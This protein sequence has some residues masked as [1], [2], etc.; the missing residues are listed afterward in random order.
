MGHSDFNGRDFNRQATVAKRFELSGIG[1]HNGTPTKIIVSPADTNTGILF[2][3]TDMDDAVEPEIPAHFSRV[4]ATELCTVLGAPNGVSVSTVEHLLSSLSAFGIDNALIEIDGAEMPI[5]D[6]SSAVFVDA[7]KKA[8]VRQQRAARRFVK[9]L[10]TVSVRHGDSF[11]EIRP[12]DGFHVD[13]EIDF[14]IALIGRQR[15]ALEVTPQSF[16]KELSRARTFG[17]MRDV[18]RLWAAG[19]ALGASLEN[20]IAIGEDRIINP[21]GTRFPDE[22]VRHKALDAVGDLALA[23]APILGSFSSRCGGHK[24]NFSL[25]SALFEDQDAWEYV[26]PGSEPVVGHADM[27]ERMPVAAFGPDVS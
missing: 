18:E 10:K 19:Y 8:G 16:E 5:M 14:P 6:G 13:V 24:L 7:V 26:R 12:H 2:I 3:R 27:G 20:T 9:V 21:E 4:C 22:F 15:F 11:G 1:V 17:F 25:L 23:G